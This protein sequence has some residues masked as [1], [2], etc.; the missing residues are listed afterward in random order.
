MRCEQAYEDG[1]MDIG[2]FS[3][4][5]LA[6]SVYVRPD[7]YRRIKLNDLVNDTIE[8]AY[9]L[10]IPPAKT[11]VHQPQKICYRINKHVGLLLMKQRQQVIKK[12]GH[13]FDKVD[14]GKM[15][16]FP[17]RRFKRDKSGWCS[18][19]A[20]ESFGEIPS[21]SSFN[22]TYFRQIQ[23]MVLNGKCGLNSN[24]L[25]H[26]IGT[27]LAELGCSAKTIQ[28]VLKH[29]DDQTC[30]AYVDIA[31]N[32]LVDELSDAM[33]PAFEACLPVFQRF[34]S[35]DDLVAPKTA[36][37]SEDLETGRIELTG[38]CGKQIR[39]KAAPFTCYECNKFIP[40]FD[41]DHNLNMDII[42]S[43]IDIYKCAGT[44]F[45]HL[46]EKAKNIKYRIQLVMA[47]CDRY[48]QFVAEQKGRS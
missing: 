48:Q 36:I 27:Q 34:M 17:S 45:R 16:L 21:G 13:L 8:D 40:C 12:H 4:I 11:G 44:P 2:Y 25:R 46:V 37:H 38:E 5:N 28:A 32:G 33:Q 22:S 18:K 9:F 23:T 1:K 3:F 26:T 42:H 47:A 15:V 39:C 43:E 24:A 6:F 30:M 35:K 10:Y 31:F 19:Y 29:A 20:N 7:S 41:A 14:I